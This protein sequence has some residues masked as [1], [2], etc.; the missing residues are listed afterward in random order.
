[1]LRS[2]IPLSKLTDQQI[3]RN[4]NPNAMEIIEEIIKIN[5]TD[6]LWTCLS[7]NPIAISILEQN[8]D[9][10]DWY[11]LSGNPNAISILEQNP[12]KICWDNLSSNPNAIQLLEEN[13]IL[14]LNFAK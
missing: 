9:K 5:N 3:C 7:E 8:I 6:L 11:Y 1:M 2:W 10:V 14:Y 4:P 13:Y 12:D